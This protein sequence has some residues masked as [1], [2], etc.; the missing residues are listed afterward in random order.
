MSPSDTRYALLRERCLR[1]WNMHPD[2]SGSVSELWGR[3]PRVLGESSAPALFADCADLVQILRAEMTAWR[4]MALA[5]YDHLDATN[6]TSCREAVQ[7]AVANE[8]AN[9]EF[10][11]RERK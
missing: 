8:I 2:A 6:R 7:A 1:Y 3:V 9:S 10:T 5:Q 11:T 4:R